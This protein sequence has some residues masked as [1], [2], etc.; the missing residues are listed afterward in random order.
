MEIAHQNALQELQE[1]HRK[2]IMELEK[3]KDKLLQEERQAAA[4]GKTDK[5]T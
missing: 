4:N 2:E 5:K 3:Q 1:R